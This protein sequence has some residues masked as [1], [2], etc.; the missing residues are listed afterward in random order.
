[1]SSFFPLAFLSLQH[2][3]A[4]PLE[5]KSHARTRPL[6]GD[7]IL[8]DSVGFITLAAFDQHNFVGSGLCLLYLLIVDAADQMLTD[9]IGCTSHSIDDGQ[10]TCHVSRRGHNGAP[11]LGFW[12]HHMFGTVHKISMHIAAVH[13]HIHHLA[14]LWH[15]HLVFLAW[16]VHY[17]MTIMLVKDIFGLTCQKNVFKLCKFVSNLSM[18]QRWLESYFTI[19]N[20]L[21]FDGKLNSDIELCCE[22]LS[23][24]ECVGYFDPDQGKCGLL[25]IS[26]ELDHQQSL[27][28]LIH[29]MTH[30]WDYHQ[31]GFTCHDQVF[32]NK[33]Q[34]CAGILGWGQLLS[35][36]YSHKI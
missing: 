7:P 1:M 34:Q 33:E 11:H 8:L 5:L 20:A 13:Q 28:V 4:S 12:C 3:L 27:L 36:K 21:L 26:N 2:M 30:F 14:H 32:L 22:S 16:C 17:S 23:D 29:E 25:T 6:L 19:F 31:R 24:M 15:I 9:I 35:V 18:N 10:T